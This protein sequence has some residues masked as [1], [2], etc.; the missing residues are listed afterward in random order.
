MNGLSKKKKSDAIM[1]AKLFDPCEYYVVLNNM[2][3]KFVSST[4][5]LSITFNK[6]VNFNDHVTNITTEE[7]RS[8][9]NFTYCLGHSK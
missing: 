9:N 6:D 3:L 1:Y 8:L 4:T 5:D 7:T 2:E